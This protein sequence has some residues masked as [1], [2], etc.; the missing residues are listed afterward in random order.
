VVFSE[1][2]LGGVIEGAARQV[3]KRD[4]EMKEA[5]SAIDAVRDPR[6]AAQI[7]VDVIAQILTGYKDLRAS[8][9][10]RQHL[11]SEATGAEVHEFGRQNTDGV[12]FRGRD[13]QTLQTIYGTAQSTA[14]IMHYGP[15]TL[16]L[17][18]SLLAG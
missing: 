17:H 15:H 1:A 6:P 7:E 12:A 13:S 3:L 16:L 2:S 4:S 14:P 5:V 11:H 9:Q 8:R 10:R 18:T